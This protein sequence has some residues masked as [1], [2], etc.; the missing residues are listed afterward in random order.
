MLIRDIRNSDADEVLA[1]YNHYISET[2]ITFEENVIDITE[3]KSRISRTLQ[4][5]F[6]WLIA[7]NQA[8]EVV[9]YAYGGV[10]KERAAYKHTV[11]ATVYLSSDYIG[12]GIGFQLY[13]ALLGQLKEQGFHSVMGVI[14]LPNEGSVRLHE[15]LGFTKAAHFSEVGYK[16]NKWV[17]VGY[18]H[19]FL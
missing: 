11:E 16:F 17:D 12:K 15:K 13:D 5:N 2:V 19:K 3:I 7:Q 4:K 10:W 18:W 14:S 9:G 8:N 1:I 6:P